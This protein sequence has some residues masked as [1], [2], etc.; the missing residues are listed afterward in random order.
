[1]LQSYYFDFL[2]IYYYSGEQGEKSLLNSP[3]NEPIWP[4][5]SAPNTQ[6]E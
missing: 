4:V 6:R 3:L 5:D 1:M 2:H